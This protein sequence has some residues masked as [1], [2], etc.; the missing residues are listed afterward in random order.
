[1]LTEQ[2]ATPLFLF[3]TPVILHDL[4][5]ADYLNEDLKTRIHAKRAEHDGLK[6]SNYGG[7]HS[8]VDMMIWAEDAARV[9]LGEA[10]NVS[11]GYT[12]DI[13]PHGKRDFEFDAQMW[14]NINAPG[15]SNQMHCHPGALWSG[16][17][18]V[19]TG[20]DASGA[21]V[22][23]ELLLLDP[24]FPMNTMY[25]PELVLRNQQGKP[26]YSQAPIRPVAGRMVLFPAWLKH[27][28][29]P[30]KGTRERISIAFNLMVSVSD[31]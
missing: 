8:E 30:Y 20:E 15:D 18:Y 14:A 26:Q 23:G 31:R 4:E 13:H 24:R 28:V 29:R 27:S 17:Y 11:S 2:P 16:V 9:I 1:M 12:A 19:D 10:I 6:R 5:G 22:E 7:W 3:S 25:M 21:D